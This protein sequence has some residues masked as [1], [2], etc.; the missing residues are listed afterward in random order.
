VIN[1]YIEHLIQSI[2]SVSLTEAIL[3]MQRRNS[4]QQAAQSLQV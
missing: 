1:N 4:M 2:V 3:N